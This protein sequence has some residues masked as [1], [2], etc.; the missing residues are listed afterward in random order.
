MIDSVTGGTLPYYYSIN[1]TPGPI[2]NGF[3]NNDSTDHLFDSL[4]A[5]WYYTDV[6]DANGCTYRDSII[7][8]QPDSLLIDSFATSIYIGGWGVSCH[9][10]S[11]GSS[12]GYVSGGTYDS[13]L[14]NYSY[15]WINNT[16]T[17]SSSDTVNN[18]QANEWYIL[19]V[20]DINGCLYF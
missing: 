15:T 10:F 12:F 8:T 4:A 19:H 17:L 9:G 3:Y 5:A 13:V 1:G 16:D 7:L 2:A 11:D 6:I 20:Q 14:Y 18:I